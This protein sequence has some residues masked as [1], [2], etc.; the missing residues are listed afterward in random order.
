MRKCGKKNTSNSR[1]VAA[2]INE[3]QSFGLLDDKLNLLKEGPPVSIPGTVETMADGGQ[4]GT[5]S[6]CVTRLPVKTKI[7][8]NRSR[9]N[10]NAYTP[11]QLIDS[12]P[13]SAN[14]S[15]FLL[16]RSEDQSKILLVAFENSDEL[17]PCPRTLFDSDWNPIYHQVISKSLFSQPCI[18]DDEIGFPAE[19]FDNLPIKLA[20]NGEWLMA[21]PSRISHNFSLFHACANGSDYYFREIAVSPYYKME[22]I[23]MSIDNDRQEMSVGFCQRIQNT[24]LKN[25]QVCNYSMKQGRV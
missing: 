3:I 15:A 18:Q 21:S 16:V 12:L 4:Q 22:D 5:R 20:N 23:A 10:E 24:S 9:L 13:F 14:A 11:A 17:N 8:W 7:F 25:V 2:D 6:D 19:S 1:H